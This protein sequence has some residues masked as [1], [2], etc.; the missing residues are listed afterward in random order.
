MS[1]IWI[2]RL[3]NRVVNNKVRLYCLVECPDCNKRREIRQD[4][5]NAVDTTCCRSCT[6]LR[7]PTKPEEDLFNWEKHYHSKE[8]KLAH[9]YQ[10]HKRRC[11]LKGWPQPSYSQEELITWGMSLTEYHEIFDA[12]TKSGYLKS[13]SPS[14]DRLDD[15]QSYSLNNIRMVTWDVNNKKGYH[16]QIV[17]KNTKNCLAVD[18]L[19]M[20][21][22]FIKRFH[23]IQAASRAL[24]IDDSKIGGVCKGLPIKKRNGFSTPVSAGGFKWRYSTIPN[25]TTN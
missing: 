4:A 9:M 18:Q 7:R 17:G 12:W 25:P 15:Y 6:N 3:P 13:L 16:W 10:Q 2:E 22:V 11:S 5:F 20:D 1:K 8:G 23:S 19:T 14:I 24:N 21:G